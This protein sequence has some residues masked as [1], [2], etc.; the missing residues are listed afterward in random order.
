MAPTP[1]FP[2]MEQRNHDLILDNIQDT[3]NACGDVW[4]NASEH[5]LTDLIPQIKQAYARLIDV[6]QSFRMYT[7]AFRESLPGDS[8]EA[9]IAKADQIKIMNQAFM[10][11]QKM[12]MLQAKEAEIDKN[13]E[14]SDEEIM[15]EGGTTGLICPLSAK[16][17]DNPVVSTSCH[18]VYDK[19]HIVRY[20]KERSR[21]RFPYVECPVAGCNAQIS[22]NTIIEDPKITKQVNQAKQEENEDYEKL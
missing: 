18:H 22:L 15:F 5:G 11:A 8:Y 21:G 20:I 3:L 17:P 13:D 2:K 19:D 12:Q 10:D 14:G 16:L 9:I 4:S 1:N 7:D 6:Q